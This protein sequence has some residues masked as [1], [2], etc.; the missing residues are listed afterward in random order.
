MTIGDDDVV[1]YTSEDIVS[2]DVVDC[3][4]ESRGRK[5]VDA[6]HEM[7]QMD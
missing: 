6:T 1:V 3:Y 2:S 5:R 7:L 4:L